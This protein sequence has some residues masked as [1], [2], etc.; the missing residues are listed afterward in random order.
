MGLALINL[1]AYIDLANHRL[2]AFNKS[3][4]YAWSNDLRTWHIHAHGLVFY[5]KED[6]ANKGTQLPMRG[7][8]TF[9]TFGGLGQVDY[10][11]TELK[12]PQD[13]QWVLQR[14][15]AQ[16][17]RDINLLG[18]AVRSVE[19]R[20]SDDTPPAYGVTAHGLVTT[21]FGKKQGYAGNTVYWK[22]PDPTVRPSG[23]DMTSS[24]RYEAELEPLEPTVFADSARYL[25]MEYQRDR[26]NLEY[27]RNDRQNGFYT[28]PY[29]DR[30]ECLIQLENGILHSGFSTA[31]WIVRQLL[32]RQLLKDNSTFTVKDG[33]KIAA[34]GTKIES[35]F[36]SSSSTALDAAI[37]KIKT[38]VS[39][40][41]AQ[42]A[43][44]EATAIVMQQAAS[45]L[46]LNA[47]VPSE[48]QRAARQFIGTAAIDPAALC[49]AESGKDVLNAAGGIA[50]RMGY[51]TPATFEAQAKMRVLPHGAPRSSLEQFA[52]QA[53]EAFPTM[54]AATDQ[55]WQD[56]Q[57]QV[58]GVITQNVEPEKQVNLIAGMR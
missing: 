42:D 4:L 22:L 38:D 5:R 37:A 29:D 36:D 12:T 47:A 54:I 20:E 56:F 2:R 39:V 32:I 6:V 24:Y 46:G 17:T 3:P 33:S 9:Q 51:F 57:H 44:E 52:K 55:M 58:A 31:A 14:A 18:F 26:R 11:G 43:I 8:P 7:L 10:F 21:V 40:G 16:L 23:H 41:T 35:I 19:G 53:Q 48:K 28:T 50:Q 13:R 1:P 25:Q 49:R 15:K 34:G 27:Y 45:A 30:R